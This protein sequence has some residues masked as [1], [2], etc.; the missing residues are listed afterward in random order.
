MVGIVAGGTVGDV[1]PAGPTVPVPL[2]AVPAAPVPLPAVP[3]VMAVPNVGDGADTSGP[4]AERVATREGEPAPQPAATKKAAR[5]RTDTA[6]T[7][8]RRAFTVFGRSGGRCG[9]APPHP[10]PC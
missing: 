2:A 8:A 9:S 7:G 10:L 3:A 6:G 5:T 4:G 1:P